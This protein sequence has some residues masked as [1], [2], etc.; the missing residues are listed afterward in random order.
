MVGSYGS[1]RLPLS[2]IFPSLPAESHSE[3]REVGDDSVVVYVEEDSNVLNVILH[4]A[5]NISCAWYCSSLNTIA[6]AIGTLPAYGLDAKLILPST[7][8]YAVL[9]YHAHLSPLEIYTLAAHY[10]LDELAISTSAHLLSFSLCTLTDK[11]VEAMGPVYLRRLL[12]L[13]LGRVDALKRVIRSPP[14]GHSPTPVC[15]LADQKKLAAAWILAAAY[16]SY[17]LNPGQ[18]L[19]SWTWSY[20]R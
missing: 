17:E 1:V 20:Q 7:P 13:H 2:T 10:G 9:L 19:I 3:N 6:T 11:C 12:F 4:M 16:L 8:L 18:L 5:Y 15:N 14:I